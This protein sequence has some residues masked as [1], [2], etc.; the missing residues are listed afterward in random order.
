MT[1]FFL[2]LH[3]HFCC[4]GDALVFLDLQKDSYTLV[5]GEASSILRS[6]CSPNNVEM[7]DQKQIDILEELVDVGL[8]TKNHDAGKHASPTE[9]GLAMESLLDTEAPVEFRITTVH[10]W[11]FI[12]ACTTAVVRLR[13]NRLEDTVQSVQL[14]KS[15]CFP[16]A[17]LPFAKARELTAIFNRLRSFFPR[18]YLCLYDS[19]ALIE[20]LARFQ[21]FPTWVF[22]VKL[23]PWAAHCWVQEA[24]F[25]FNEGA[26][27]AA[28]YTAVMTI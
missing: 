10:V 12:A 19:L 24:P 22:G 9:I 25:T 11:R 14:R 26:E 6:M 20:F 8:L 2:P 15:C 5:N 21:L 3:V 23:E 27:E 4:R 28:G 16:K 1:E 17:P 7:L 13:W 18:N